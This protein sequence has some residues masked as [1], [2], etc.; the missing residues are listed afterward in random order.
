V[1][2]SGIGPGAAVAKDIRL[3]EMLIAKGAQPHPLGSGIAQCE[4]QEIASGVTP[5]TET[6]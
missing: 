3:A 4:A 6:N 5:K 1:A 2:A